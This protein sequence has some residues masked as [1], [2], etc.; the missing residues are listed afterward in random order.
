MKSLLLGTCF[1]L[2][3][4]FSFAQA[5]KK[6]TKKTK[7]DACTLVEKYQVLKSD[8]EVKHGDYSA[9]ILT[10]TEKGQYNLGKQSGIWEFSRNTEVHQKFDFST[11]KFLSDQPSKF[12]KKIILQDN[13]DKPG[14]EI[15]AKNFYLGGDPKMLTIVKKCLKYPREAMENNVMGEALLS[16]TLTKEGEIINEKAE[17]QLGF[18]LEEEWLR[19]FKLIPPTWVP[20]MVNGKPVDAKLYFR[21]KFTLVT[22]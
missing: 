21:F 6:V 5:L 20:I 9:Q 2:I 13:N 4:S 11:G 12:I 7:I 3:F 22:I 18:G 1:S 8:S 10:Y 14:K 17:S 16:A 15:E 19:V